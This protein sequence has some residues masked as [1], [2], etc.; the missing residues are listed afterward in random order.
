MKKIFMLFAGLFF[1]LLSTTSVNALDVVLLITH[2]K[3]FFDKWDKVAVDTAPTLINSQQVFV[4]QELLIMPLIGD[5]AVNSDN[6][7][8][9]G[10][11]IQLVEPDGKIGFEKKD[12]KSIDSVIN[13]PKI[14]RVSADY[15]KL[16]FDHQDKPGKY[17]IRVAVQDLVSGVTII[18]EQQIELVEYKYE[19]YFTDYKGYKN[20][21]N[22]Y[23]RH[24]SP[25]KAID[26]LIFYSKLPPADRDKG[27]PF[28][29]AFFSKIFN[30][31]QYLI[32]FLLKEYQTQ[33][34]DTKIAILGILPYLEYDP[35]DFINN[36]P[37]K[38]RQFYLAWAKACPQYPQAGFQ[39]QFLKD[40]MIQASQ[41]DM[42]WGTFMAS[43]EYK[44]VRAIVD[45]LE[46]GRYTG[47]FDK[48][49]QSKQEEDQ[50][51]AACDLV[52]RTAKWSL[53]SNKQQH[54]LVREY[55]YYIYEHEFLS[56]Q[57]KSELAG[58]LKTGNMQ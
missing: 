30:D 34:N 28:A 47:Y 35:G 31:N 20:W 46:L 26:G 10:Y 9:V 29:S 54:Q 21:F 25:E 12:L 55:C 41:L 40:A 39:P 32:P 18:K 57:V 24:P 16:S 2:D 58:I 49:T 13:T 17:T 36:L 22:T 53:N 50:A 51:N 23:Y 52:Y 4:K 37:E 5:P 38:E 27:F 43:G 33:N 6:Q 7:A 8:K 1:L 19:K 42:L 45:V 3:A 44:P 48:Y 56:K 15:T 11:A 14:F